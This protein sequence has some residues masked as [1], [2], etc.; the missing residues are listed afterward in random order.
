VDEVVIEQAGIVADTLEERLKKGEDAAQRI[1]D[2]KEAPMWFRNCRK[3][4]AAASVMAVEWLKHALVHAHEDAQLKDQ[5]KL[6]LGCYNFTANLLASGLFDD[7]R[8][9]S[10]AS[11]LEMGEVMKRYYDDQN[12]SERLGTMDVPPHG[13]KERKSQEYFV[14]WTVGPPDQG[15]FFRRSFTSICYGWLQWQ[16]TQTTKFL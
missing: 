14:P 1:M 6:L 5:A 11:G 15:L 7:L 16:S 13:G 2:G 3:E 9:F 4:F 10:R 8:N 12:L